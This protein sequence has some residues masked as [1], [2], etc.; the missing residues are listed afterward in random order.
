MRLYLVQHGEATSVEEDPERP[1]TPAGVDQVT[2]VA[3][4]AT[5]AGVVA[6]ERILHS[7]KAR[8]RQTADIWGDGLGV[9]VEEAEGL[10]PLDDPATWATRLAADPSDVLVA[11]HLPHLARLAGLL[12]AGDPERAVVAFR[13]GGLVALEDDGAGV[14]SVTVVLPP[15]VA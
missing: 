3:R 6:V 15:T 9:P 4:F 1:L 13:N 14:W 7:G 2:R 8:A 10:A 11:G 12:V 5:R